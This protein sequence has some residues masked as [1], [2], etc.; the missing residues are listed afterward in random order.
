LIPLTTFLT[1][2]I[3][4]RLLYTAGFAAVFSGTFLL[5]FPQHRAS[6]DLDT[7]LTFQLWVVIFTAI[8]GHSAYHLVR[9]NFFQAKALDAERQKSERLL[10]NILPGPVATRLKA[11]EQP[12]A[13]G[14]SDVTVL[15]ADIAGFTPFAERMPPHELVS[16]LNAIFSRFDALAE[17]QGLEKIKT[18]GDAYMLAAGIPEPRADHAEAVVEMA[19]DMVDAAREFKEP[20]G[21]PIQ[22]RIGINTG[23]VVAG[24]IGTKK[25][26]YDLWGD[27]VNTASRM[28]SHGL[29]GTIQLSETTRRLLPDR[30]ALEPRGPVEIKGKG[31]MKTWLVQGRRS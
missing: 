5:G 19:L 25:F 10:L 13:D 7:A 21:S 15:F 3:L 9:V 22:M 28:E 23:P 27:T 17:R 18:I 2:P 31:A 30:Y 16:L 26:I 1:V 29:R 12:I 11:N 20:D 6:P 24:V 8:L 4:P 14:F